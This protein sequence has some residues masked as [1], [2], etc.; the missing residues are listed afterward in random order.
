MTTP[1][2]FP[3]TTTT[4]HQFILVAYALCSCRAS[5]R[6]DFGIHFDCSKLG[7]ARSMFVRFMCWYSTRKR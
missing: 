1:V 3:C 5:R 7:R 4:G 2:C 6:H